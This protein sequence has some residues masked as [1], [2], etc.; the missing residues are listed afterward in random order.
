MYDIKGLKM[1]HKGNGKDPKTVQDKAQA[2]SMSQ[3][4]ML[5]LVT[6]VVLFLGGWLC[7]V[8]TMIVSYWLA[9]LR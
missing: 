4:A 7:G 9:S 5:M 1:N 3:A 8:V 2:K 6:F